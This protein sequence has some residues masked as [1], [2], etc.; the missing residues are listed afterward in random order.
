MSFRTAPA[1]AL[2]LAT[3]LA[4]SPSAAADPPGSAKAR[5]AEAEKR[6]AEQ[7]RQDTELEAEKQLAQQHFVDAKKLYQEGRYPEAKAELLEARRHDA[8]A[9]DLVFNLGIVTEKM[10]DYDEAIE[11][12]REYQKLD[13][14][15]EE[16]QRAEAIIRRIEGARANRKDN[17]QVV[18]VVERVEV[19]V[20]APPSRGRIDG[21]T[22]GGLG[23]TG[24][25]L[26]TGAVF[27]VLALGAKPSD[28]M[29]AGDTMP[30][31]RIHD[32]NDRAQ[33]FGLVSDIG[34][35]VAIVAAA[36]TAVLYF[37]RTKPQSRSAACV[38]PAPCGKGATLRLG[39]LGFDF[40]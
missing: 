25:A 18:R 17:T 4:V 34:F 39:S 36:T 27:G 29:V 11:H 37:A 38:P 28:S 40:P 20:A 2:L 6:D 7:R 13:V 19:P 12:F 23:L 5:K 35:G 33:R 32:D 15:A 9:K 8:E 1:L 24:A 16:S 26:A 14:S 30:Y 3:T 31:A 10:Q 21:W 22:V